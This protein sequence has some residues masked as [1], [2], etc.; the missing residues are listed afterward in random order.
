MKKK[1]STAKASSPDEEKEQVAPEADM[2]GDKEVDFEDGKK[3]GT[4]TK[5]R[6]QNSSSVSFQ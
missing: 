4:S 3:P 1:I 6:A 5:E 2:S